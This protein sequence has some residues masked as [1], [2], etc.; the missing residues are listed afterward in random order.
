MRMRAGERLGIGLLDS[1][2]SRSNCFCTGN[3]SAEL[4]YFMLWQIWKHLGQAFA[5]QTF[6]TVMRFEV[7]LN[8]FDKSSQF[9]KCIFVFASGDDFRKRVTWDV[10]DHAHKRLRLRRQ[11]ID[12]LAH[13]LAKPFLVACQ[14][15]GHCMMKLA[16]IMHGC[17]GERQHVDRLFSGRIGTPEKIFR[18]V[19]F[20]QTLR[21]IADFLSEF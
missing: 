10:L 2:G 18:A 1:A 17:D 3:A 14:V 13:T 7:C 6:R 16:V 9:L 21:T 8:V 12:R 5:V 19:Q 4:M 15:C 11:V 20:A